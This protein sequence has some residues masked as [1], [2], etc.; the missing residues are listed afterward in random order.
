MRQQLR[1]GRMATEM[2]KDPLPMAAAQSP[3]PWADKVRFQKLF[4]RQAAR[5]Y[6]YLSLGMGLLAFLMPIALVLTGGYEGTSP[7]V[8]FIM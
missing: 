8:S 3:L 7:S 5:S 6:L 1:K 2:G 4:S